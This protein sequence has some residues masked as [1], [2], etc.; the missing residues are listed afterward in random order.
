M[1]PLAIITG[2]LLGTSASIGA[3]LTVV[4]FLFFLLSDQHPR[5][6]AEYPALIESTIIFLIMTAI[7][8]ISFLGLIRRKQWRWLSQAAMWAGLAL[9]VVYYL[10]ET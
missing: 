6:A 10:P 2:I 5:L 7:C 1:P 9:T 8:G 3:G 4:L